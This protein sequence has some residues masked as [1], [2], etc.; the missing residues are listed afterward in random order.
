MQ[1]PAY[2]HLAF[3]NQN[4]VLNSAQFLVPKSRLQVRSYMTIISRSKREK[5]FC[6]LTRG[7]QSVW[8]ALATLLLDSDEECLQEITGEAAEN[9]DCISALILPVTLLSF[10]L[11]VRCVVQ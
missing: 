4:L 5:G 9:P 6:F 10:A 3:Y 11:T 1:V 8:R 7:N 2:V